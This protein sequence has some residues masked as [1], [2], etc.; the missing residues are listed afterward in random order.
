VVALCFGLGIVALHG[1][2]AVVLRRQRIAAHRLGQRSVSRE[3]EHE[4]EPMEE[5]SIRPGFDGEALAVLGC[6]G[7]DHEVVV[8]S[9]E[10][11]AALVQ[12]QS[13]EAAVEGH[14]AAGPPGDWI[15]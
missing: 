9:V 3:A 14:P 13:A 12:R 15:S 7:I 5:R 2:A 1:K 11:V 8:L 6:N 4:H 10:A